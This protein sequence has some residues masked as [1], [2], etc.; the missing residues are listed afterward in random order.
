[1]GKGK[2]GGD[3]WWKILLALIG[4]ASVVGLVYSQTGWGKD[5][6]ALIP[7]EVERHIDGGVEALNRRFGKRWVEAG[8]NVVTYFL[9]GILPPHLVKLADAIV[10][11][12]LESRRR[13]MTS[14]DKKQAAAQ[15]VL[16]G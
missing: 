14:Y 11:V 15:M 1:M 13:P 2:G 8:K 12:E 5:N 7:D 10:A 4:G 3:D 9:R 16:A 6:A